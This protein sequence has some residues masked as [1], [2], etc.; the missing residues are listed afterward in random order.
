MNLKLTALFIVFTVF[1][2][3]AFAL[4]T[5]Y[6]ANFSFT[7][8]FSQQPFSTNFGSEFRIMGSSLGT[9]Y[10]LSF[11]LKGSN[12]E[13]AKLTLKFEELK[14]SLYDNQIF[15]TTNDPIVLYQ[16][17]TGQN[18]V[19][20]GYGNYKLVLFNSLDLM[21][22]SGNINEIVF[23]V[24]K[25]GNLI[26]TAASYNIR[27]SSAN[28]KTECIIQ[29]ITSFDP[30]NFVGLALLYDQKQNWGVRYVF[31]GGKDTKLSY[32]P[33]EINEQNNLVLWYKFGNSPS[34]NTYLTTY[35]GFENP[36]RDLIDNSV[37][38]LDITLGQMYLN[39]KKTGFSSISGLLPNN[40]GKF[41][42]AA[43]TQFSIFDFS[44]KLGYGFGKPIHNSI[45]TIGELFYIEA[46]RNFGNISL[47]SKYQ[48]I[49]G[50]YEEKD[51]FYSEIKFTGFS[52]GDVVVRVG[53]GDFDK[54]NPFKPV[55]GIYFNLWW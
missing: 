32:S 18:G 25:R 28:L 26:D 31:A 23:I 12:L 29:N 11:S 38:G 51:F 22:L 3:T 13:S 40:W 30:K 17:T 33:Q 1:S 41:Y 53:N 50:Y 49:V 44:T 55:G 14:L 20:I 36:T 19:E 47:F 45:S 43:G 52:N 16:I 5:N 7:V 27:L 42:I 34:F 46:S 6:S 2:I 39:L 4:Q 54:D 10:D 35:F 9:G 15:G 48:K 37:V 8:D 24:G 21:Y